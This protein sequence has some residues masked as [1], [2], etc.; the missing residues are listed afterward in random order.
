MQ[1]VGGICEEVKPADDN[2]KQIVDSV[3]HDFASKSGHGGQVNP[4]H[5]KTQ[6]VAGTNYFVKV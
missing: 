5:Y 4:V 2:V 1:K 3:H 6:V